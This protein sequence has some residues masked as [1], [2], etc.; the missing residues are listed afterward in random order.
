MRGGH[1]ATH[2]VEQVVVEENQKSNLPRLP[3]VKAG[4]PD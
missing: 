2:F 1:E 3:Q 4:L